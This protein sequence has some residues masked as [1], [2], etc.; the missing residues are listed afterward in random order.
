MADVMARTR[1]HIDIRAESEADT[2][3]LRAILEAAG[4]VVQRDGA[5]LRVAA[6]ATRAAELNRASAAGGVT[7]SGLT[8]VQDSLEDI[9]LAMTGATDGDLRDQGWVVR[10][11]EVAS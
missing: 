8:V 2:E 6:E 1:A 3:R 5:T 4:W 10:R 9:F 7:L 11:E